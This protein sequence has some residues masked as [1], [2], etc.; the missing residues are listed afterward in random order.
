MEGDDVIEALC[1][2]MQDPTKGCVKILEKE[3]IEI[4]KKKYVKSGPNVAVII[5]IVVLLL[6]LF[7]LF[8]VL[9]YRRMV[10]K[11][12]SKEMSDQVNQAVAN[13]IQFYE[14]KDK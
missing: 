3:G 12:M 4:I 10:R 14:K 13:Y 2:T 8:M 6:V 11:E 7:F 1:A 5:A 9:I